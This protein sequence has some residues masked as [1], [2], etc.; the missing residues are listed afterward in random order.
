LAGF[1][2]YL[3]FLVPALIVPKTLNEQTF[4]HRLYL[5]IIG[6][7]LILPETVI[8]RGVKEQNLLYA[9]FGLAGVMGIA[10][11]NHQQ[12][13]TD[14]R[15]FWTHAVETTPNS[16]FANMMMGARLNEKEIPKS[17]ALFRKAYALNPDEKYLNYYYGKM[18]QMQDSVMASEAHLLKEKKISNY[19]ECDFYLARVAMEKHDTTG[20]INYLL[21]YIKRDKK[22]EAA[23]KNLLLMLVNK[24]DG[25]RAKEQLQRMQAN[26]ISVPVAFAQQV[27]AMR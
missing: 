18:L 22:N 13:F 1:I 16:A 2:I 25:V 3:L 6:I 19:Y 5:P 4:E 7:L 12:C 15:T 20:A 21:D 14:P 11:Y 24:G 10:N 26:G 9:S 8:F 17:F 23:N 27:N